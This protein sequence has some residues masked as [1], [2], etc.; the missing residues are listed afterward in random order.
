MARDLVVRRRGEIVGHARVCGHA[1]IFP[2]ELPEHH[3]DDYGEEASMSMDK[4]KHKAALDAL[5]ELIRGELSGEDRARFSR[6]G[7]LALIGQKLM[8]EM[9]PRA[10]DIDDEADMDEFGQIGG[11]GV[12]NAPRR[13]RRGDLLAIG[14]GADSQ[15]MVREMLAMFTPAMGGLQQQ[16]DAKRRE[17]M[18]RELNELLSAREMLQGTVA[19]EPAVE[20]LTT[21]IDA[22][23]TAMGEEEKPKG[24]EDGLSMVPA[25]GVRRHQ[26]EP[27]LGGLDQGDP[28][29]P[30]ADRERGGEG[31]LG[32]GDDAGRAPQAV[33]HGG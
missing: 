6:V 30:L 20:K 16:N 29:W 13:R 1:D 10:E 24:D 8:V 2:E 28:Q 7:R 33:G 18:A 5:S 3:D 15:Q 31:A 23:L 17:S 19:N 9:N 21:R 14:P 26:T 12:Y 27:G 4:D 25:V 32:A 11:V 22:I